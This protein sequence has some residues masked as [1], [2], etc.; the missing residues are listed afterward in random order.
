MWAA[1]LDD[2]SPQ[3]TKIAGSS[4]NAGG[5]FVAGTC[6]SAGVRLG[7]IHGLA[8]IPDVG[9]GSFVAVVHS[10]SD[11]SVGTVIEVDD[12][13]GA[14]CAVKLAAASIG[15][16]ALHDPHWPI[17]VGTALYVLERTTDGTDKITQIPYSGNTG[18]ASISLAGDL[19][20]GD[21]VTGVTGIGNKIYLMG[22][23]AAG[24]GAILEVD[25]VTP[26]SPKFKTIITGDQSVWGG[27]GPDG[28][29]TDGTGLIAWADGRAFYITLGGTKKAFCGDQAYVFAG[30][31]EN[32]SDYSYT[33]PKDC[34]ATGPDHEPLLIYNSQE[35]AVDANVF[36][37]Y[38][39]S[40]TDSSHGKLYFTGSFDATGKFVEALDCQVYP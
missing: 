16:G 2:A 36:L 7:N 4:D 13:V 1:K 34:T 29:T 9:D 8:A 38:Q 21:Y 25:V 28:L 19:L 17:F 6:A 24:G 12:P 37:D 27:T 14:G 5:D 23:L 10:A 20:D 15:A 26:T 31:V 30:E 32:L 3:F 33:T 11:N 18:T 40:T 35:S 22:S 39:P